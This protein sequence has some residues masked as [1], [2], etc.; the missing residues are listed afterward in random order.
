MA[1]GHLLHDA[2]DVARGNREGLAIALGIAGE[3][4]ADIGNHRF[5]AG[6][7]RPHLDAAARHGILP[8]IERFQE[9]LPVLHDP[10]IPQ[11]D[12][13]LPVEQGGQGRAIRGAQGIVPGRRQPRHVLSVGTDAPD[14]QQEGHDETRE[15]PVAAWRTTRPAFPGTTGPAIRP[16]GSQQA[17]RHPPARN[18][19][20]G[21]P[22]GT[23]HPTRCR[24]RPRA[25]AAS[26]ALPGCERRERS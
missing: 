5:C 6:G 8:G 17:L 2:D 26:R 7:Q 18:R 9:F 16:A 25:V 20:S 4:I 15:Q 23:I 19:R 22:S 24:T 11:F 1:R 21:D 12:G 14:C 13:R 3:S 10:E